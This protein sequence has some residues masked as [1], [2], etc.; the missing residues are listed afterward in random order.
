MKRF[1][2]L[3][4]TALAAI[5]VLGVALAQP[6]I[7]AFYLGKISKTGGGAAP[8]GAL[9]WAT[10]GDYISP[11]ETVSKGQYYVSV[12]PPSGS[13]AAQAVRFWIDHDGNGPL[14]GV[15]A[16]PSQSV[17]FKAGDTRPSL[18]LVYTPPLAPPVEPTATPLPS[19][20]PEPPP[21][22]SPTPTPVPP[23]P[24]LTPSPPT[25]TPTPTP[26]PTATLT[27]TPTPEPTATPSPVP[28]TP[29]PT[30]APKK[31]G[32]CSP[33]LREEGGWTMGLLTLAGL[34]MPAAA[35]IWF[36]R[37]RRPEK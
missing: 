36:E 31:G 12:G 14:V 22:P 29:T 8:D 25:R 4:A 6:P 35:G 37:R 7:G 33:A 1:L 17:L 3:V 26:I 24:T 19:P 9:V 23:T 34:M 21:T 15:E 28:A 20:P 27:A 11:K 5:S 2:T 13:Y 10:V 30:P 32:G 18:D 16:T